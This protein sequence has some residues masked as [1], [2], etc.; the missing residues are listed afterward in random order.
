MPQP[1]QPGLSEAARLI[2]TFIAPRKTFE[3][4]KRKSRW[5]VPFL[6]GCIALSAYFYT[7]G[8]KV[9]F[10]SIVNS[11][12]A[13]ASFLEKATAQLTPEQK[14]TMFDRQ[15]ASMR[16]QMYTA[17]IGSLIIGLIFAAILM[18]TFNFG[19]DAQVKY[20]TALA[21]VYYGWLPK[22]IFSAVAIVVMIVGV[23]PE[24]FDMENPVATNLGVLLGSNTDQRFLYHLLGAIDLFSLW[25]VFL[26][27]LGFATVS[28]KKISTGAAVTAVAAWYVLF[29]LLRAA[30][31]PFAG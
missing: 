15:M 13:H 1:A 17:P 12:F 19:F 23:E 3:D 4:L 29:T 22:I 30:A 9:G 16:R 14:Q 24:G 5:W 8:K 10:E 20:K 31:S 18:A 26:M 25:W 27:G 11:T 28:Q 6:L 7:V 2:D 21:V